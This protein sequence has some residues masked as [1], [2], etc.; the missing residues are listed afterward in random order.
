MGKRKRDR[1][2]TM[3]VATT[4][5]PTTASHPFYARL[6]RLLADKRFDDFAE[7]ACQAFYADKMGRP[8]LPPGLYFRLRP[9]LGALSHRVHHCDVEPRTRRVARHVCRPGPRAE[10][11]RSLHQQRLRSDHRGRIVSTAAQTAPGHRPTGA[12][13]MTA[14]PRDAP[15]GRPRPRRGR[16]PAASGQHRLSV[17]GRRA[18]PGSAPTRTTTMI[19]T[20]KGDG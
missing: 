3:W 4:D 8:G 17:D 10:R 11:H 16:S 1:Q 18:P 12:H 20:W 15:I 9:A 2:P 14:D 6:N 13:A 19:E 5:L 7:T